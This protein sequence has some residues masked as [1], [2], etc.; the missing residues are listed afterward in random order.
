LSDRWET[1]NR[2]SVRNH[3]FGNLSLSASYAHSTEIF[4]DEK[5]NTGGWS[6][7]GGGQFNKRVYLSVSYRETDAIFYSADPYQGRSTRASAR[8]TYQPSDKI[9]SDFNLT[10]VDFHR[11]SDGEKIYDYPIYWGR[12]TY[13]LNKYLLFRGIAEYNDYR[14]ELLTDLLVS[15]TYIPGTVVHLGYGSLRDRIRWD[16]S[17]YLESDRFLETKRKLFFKTSYLWR[18]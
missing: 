3:L 1:Y 15:F 7:A 13:Q 6:L 17:D 10:Y 12:L 2:I 5:F 14:E 11:E 4:L 18:R 8:L 9:Q 16:G